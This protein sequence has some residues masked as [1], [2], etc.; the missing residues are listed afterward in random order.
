MLN[1][2]T[3]SVQ[4][5]K[6]LN[7]PTNGRCGSLDHQRHGASGYPIAGSLSNAH[8]VQ[9]NPKSGYKK[10]FFMIVNAQLPFFSTFFIRH[11]ILKV[12]M[13][14]HSSS[15]EKQSQLYSNCHQNACV[16]FLLA[17][18]KRNVTCEE[19]LSPGAPY[20][21]RVLTVSHEYIMLSW[22]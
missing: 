8:A 21:K 7:V 11:T 16:L 6:D 18:L 9:C 19:L 14:T 1:N 15:Q 12:K 17:V 5:T 3:F 2:F 22:P 4:S 20:V 13:N 10:A